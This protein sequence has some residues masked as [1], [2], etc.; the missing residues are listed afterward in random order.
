MPYIPQKGGPSRR[1]SEN[2][3]FRETALRSHESGKLHVE[4]VIQPY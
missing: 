1:F 3:P 4:S 2:R